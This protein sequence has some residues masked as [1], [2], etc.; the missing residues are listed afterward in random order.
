MWVLL[1]LPRRGQSSIQTA[2]RLSQP[3]FGVPR[4]CVV[5]SA[6][7]EGHRTWV[8]V[9][10]WDLMAHLQPAG[11]HKPVSWPLS[12]LVSCFCVHVKHPGRVR[13]RECSV[14][15]W[16]LG[17][18]RSCP[19]TSFLASRCWCKSHHLEVQQYLHVHTPTTLHTVFFICC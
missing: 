19:S 12:A 16:G 10:W 9:C 13:V 18:P 2:I 3:S 15:V 8:S 17:E 11:N 6:P 7:P 5:V 1:F 14:Q 4:G